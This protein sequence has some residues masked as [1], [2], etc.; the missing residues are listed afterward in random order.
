MNMILHGILDA[1]IQNGHDGHLGYHD[2]ARVAP[3]GALQQIVAP[4]VAG[5]ESIMDVLTG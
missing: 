5:L 4:S 3:D 1:D 2:G